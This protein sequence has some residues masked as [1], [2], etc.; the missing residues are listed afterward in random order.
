MLLLLLLRVCV[1]P[2]FQPS[3]VVLGW[4]VLLLLLD[5]VGP[6]VGRV[7]PLSASLQQS[8]AHVSNSVSLILVAGLHCT[9]SAH[10]LLFHGEGDD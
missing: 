7:F 5:T 9:I 4:P 6:A 2:G 8:A 1:V 10:G 3:V